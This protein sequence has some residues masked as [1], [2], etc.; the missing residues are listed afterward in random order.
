MIDRNEKD[1]TLF[2]VVPTGWRAVSLQNGSL[3]IVFGE[4]T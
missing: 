2:F 4:L 3:E 1:R